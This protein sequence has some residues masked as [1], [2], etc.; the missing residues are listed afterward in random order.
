MQIYLINLD[1]HP[2]RLQ[3]MA[4]LLHGLPF[5]RIAAVDG[6]MVAGPEQ[7]DGS[8]PSGGENLSRY[9]K[10]CALSHRAAWQEFLAGQETYACILEDDI[11][12]GPDFSRFIQDE[13]W[14]PANC[15]LMKIETNNHKVFVARA[16]TKCLDRTASALLSLHFGT[17]A[18]IVSRRG[19]AALL[20]RTTVMDR[21]CDR[22][23]FD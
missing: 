10:A 2:L 18:Y 20:E 19:A 13:S 15:D 17:A 12:I 4:N 3:R 14:I 1:R 16:K 7:R 21:T 8:R 11:F 22:L 23:V 9:E 5:K 6:R